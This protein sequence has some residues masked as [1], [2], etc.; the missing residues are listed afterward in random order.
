MAGRTPAGHR[1][2]PW[3]A[4]A[5]LAIGAAAVAG[6]GACAPITTQLE[7]S[8]SDGIRA[9]LGEELSVENLLVLTTGQGEPAL[10]V[11]GL[12]NHTAETITV[13][14]TF[15]DAESVDIPI[16]G[17]DTV[18]LN[19]AHEGG[20]TTTLSASPV[21]P[22]ANL[23]VTISTPASGSTTANVTVLDGTLEPYGTYLEF[24]DEV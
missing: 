7:Y 6:V 5:A 2:H 17:N 16:A 14:L 11:G 3:R 21:P 23:P 10:V 13:T 19:P 22:G 9:D 20:L 18:L 4:L 1:R 24:L 15:G 8:P 12:T